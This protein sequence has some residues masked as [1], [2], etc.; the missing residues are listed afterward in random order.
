M[1]PETMFGSMRMAHVEILRGLFDPRGRTDRFGYLLTVIIGALAGHGF[2]LF[3]GPLEPTTASPP[4]WLGYG[5]AFWLFCVPNVRRLHDIGHS[6]WWFWAAIPATLIWSVIVSVATVAAISA[7]GG[8]VLDLL[9]SGQPV[10]YVMMALVA[11]P[12]LAAGFWLCGARGMP[13]ETIYGP[14]PMR[15]GLSSPKR[16]V[17]ESTSLSSPAT[18]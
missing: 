7:F 16:S 17:S 10:Y 8:E 14:V 9:Q 3:A 6:G 15:F 11:A 4:V 5:I 12:V 13:V 1:I 18:T 2:A